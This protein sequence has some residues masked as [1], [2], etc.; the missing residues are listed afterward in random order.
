MKITVFMYSIPK[1]L[2]KKDNPQQTKPA[3]KPTTVKAAPIPTAD[4]HF[5]E[6]PK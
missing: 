3:N 1:S 2:N 6:I 4:D 5:L